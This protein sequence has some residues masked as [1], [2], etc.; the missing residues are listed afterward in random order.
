MKKNV[1]GIYIFE[2]ILF[3][4]VIMF[5]IFKIY[6]AYN[7]ILILGAIFCYL[8]FG[9]ARDNS[10]EKTNI[11]KIVIASV[12]A[13]AILIY[14]LGLFTGFFRI[15]IDLNSIL[16]SILSVLGIVAGEVIR[17][18]IAKNSIKSK[19]P[20]IVFTILFIILNIVTQINGVALNDRWRIFVFVSTIV[21]PI[22][23]R[24]MMCSYLA[25]N[26]SS[27]PGIIYRLFT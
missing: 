19:K 10:Y 17:Y 18:I 1:K 21:I 26:C 13:G 16:V 22:I 7:I 24:D 12:M 2:I 25:Y 3:I 23:A 4:S 11:I 6:Y 8:R 27:V 5:N 14:S 9:Y 15:T 20:F